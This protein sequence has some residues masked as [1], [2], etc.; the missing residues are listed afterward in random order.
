MKFLMKKSVL[1]LVAVFAVLV[2]NASASTCC[3]FTVHQP[4][5]PEALRK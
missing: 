2:A 5:F 3:F 1:S 4:K